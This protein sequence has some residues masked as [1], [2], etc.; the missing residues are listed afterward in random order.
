MSIFINGFLN[1]LNRQYILKRILRPL[2]GVG[3]TQTQGPVHTVHTCF[4][5]DLFLCPKPVPLS[6][7]DCQ[8]SI[9]YPKTS[10]KNAVCMFGESMSSMSLPS[11]PFTHGP[12]VQREDCDPH[13]FLASDS[14]PEFRLPNYKSGVLSQETILPPQK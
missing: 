14:G 9:F 10:H 3:G 11:I 12:I 13:G 7:A 1:I 2:L 8:G 5:T 4:S 6:P